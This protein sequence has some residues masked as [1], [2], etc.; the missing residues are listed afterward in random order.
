MATDQKTS[1]IEAD[2]D[3]IGS[4]IENELP[5]YRAI[6]RIAVF[7]FIFGFLASFSFAHWFF[8]VFAIL[9]IVAGAAAKLRIKRYPDMFTG[10]GLASAG[11]AMGLVFGLGAATVAT[12]QSYVRSREAEKFAKQLVL[13]LKAPTAGEALWWNLHPD[14]R[15]DKTPAQY[16]HEVELAKGKERMM[17]EQRFG[18]LNRIR[19]RL[20]AAPGEDIHFVKIESTGIDEGRGLELGVYSLAVFELE[21]PGS[22]E[23]PEKEQFAAAFLKAR[24][25]GKHYEW[26]VDTYLFPYQP[27]SFV[28]VEKPVDDGHGHAH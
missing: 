3:Q 14:M 22:K 19:R 1:L 13:A 10:Q 6:N 11:I 5:A 16:L 20:T 8:Y 23:F 28:P 12:V 18:T 25:T 26:W 17:H 2:R 15:K 7:S 4:V 24:T 27:S 21:G 9:A